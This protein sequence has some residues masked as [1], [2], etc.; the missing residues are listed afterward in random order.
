[1]KILKALGIFI[2][3]VI[4]IILIA[5]IFLPKETT[6]QKSIIIKASSKTIFQEVNT[7]KKWEDWGPYQESDPT[8]EI[9]YSGPEEGE[10]AK[11][12]W[13]SKD[14]GDGTFEITRSLPFKNI[15]T[16]IDFIKNGEAIGDWKF[17]ELDS[18]KTK[19]DWTVSIQ[20]LA[21]PIGRI[22]GLFIDRGI[23]PVLVK[24]LKSLKR[25]AEKES[26]LA[27]IILSKG[28]A[29]HAL[30]VIDS[31]NY[32]NMTTRFALDFNKIAKF[33]LTKNYTITGPPFSIF[34]NSTMSGI[35]FKVG[36]PISSEELGENNIKYEFF[37]ES[38][39]LETIHY[40][41]YNSIS[42]TYNRLNNEINKKNLKIIGPAME[43]YVTDPGAVPDTNK[44]ETKVL[45]PIKK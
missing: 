14:I 32:Q 26:S 4:V 40:G 10:K 12:S 16:K 20:N 18:L 9:T 2:I 43:I 37:P 45:I 34:D 1:M 21:Y 5:G 8:I 36:I 25:T 15:Q 42:V 33:I 13:I 22:Y 27:P 11:M 39:Y 30:I 35:S 17:Q 3:I 19:V 29:F 6:I 41:N 24:G 44:W 7:P 38:N 23:G 28:D 31:S